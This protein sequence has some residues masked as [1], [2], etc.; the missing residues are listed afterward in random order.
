MCSAL[1]QIE[2]ASAVLLLYGERVI[3]AVYYKWGCKMAVKMKSV[4][5]SEIKDPKIVREVIAREEWAATRVMMDETPVETR[6]RILKTV[7]AENSGNPPYKTITMEA[8]ESVGSGI[9]R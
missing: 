4:G 6:R 3:V 8:T 2:A 7:E 5:A 9:A 1:A